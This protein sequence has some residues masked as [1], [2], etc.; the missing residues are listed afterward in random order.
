MSFGRPSRTPDTSE[1]WRPQHLDDVLARHIVTWHDNPT[2]ESEVWVARRLAKLSHT[3]ISGQD[4]ASPNLRAEAAAK[5]KT[6]P[7]TAH[8]ESTLGFA[9][10]N[11]LSTLAAWNGHNAS[12]IWLGNL[13]AWKIN[14]YSSV[15]SLFLQEYRD[16]AMSD[17]IFALTSLLVSTGLAAQVTINPSES[18]SSNQPPVEATLTTSVAGINPFAIGYDYLLLPPELTLTMLKANS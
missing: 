10:V 3:V 12:V 18:R 7:C 6:G 5:S 17:G 13:H 2:L 9:S 4:M 16:Q 15:A 14:A 1:L 11:G 8:V